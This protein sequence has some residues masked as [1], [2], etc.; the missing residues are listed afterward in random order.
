MHMSNKNYMGKIDE[1]ATGT[2][3]PNYESFDIISKKKCT[4]CEELEKKYEDIIAQYTKLKDDYLE[5]EDAYLD[6]KSRDEE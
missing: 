4:K 5:L 2:T 1:D 6:L 3:I